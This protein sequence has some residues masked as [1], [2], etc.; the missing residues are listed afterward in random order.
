V[1]KETTFAEDT[2][3]GKLLHDTL[4]ALAAGVARTARR[5]GVAGRV[6][7]LKIRF[8]GFETHTRQ[9]RL[10]VP[11]DNEHLVLEQAWDLYLR[12]GFEGRPVRLVGVGLSGLGQPEPIQPDLFEEQADTLRSRR[13]SEALDQ[14]RERFGPGALQWGLKRGPRRGG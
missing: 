12:G 4:R 3:D 5:E 7:T 1:S 10:E 2:R 8:A 9:R 14:V 11:T 13:A 6:V